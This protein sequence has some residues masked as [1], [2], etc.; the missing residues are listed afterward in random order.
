MGCSVIRPIGSGLR[1]R[2]HATQ[3]NVSNVIARTATPIQNGSGRSPLGTPLH[4]LN[5]IKTIKAATPS[6]MGRMDSSGV[7]KICRSLSCTLISL[8]FYHSIGEHPLVHLP[9]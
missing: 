2:Y 4:E 9:E 3:A 7:L 8:S 1:R 5:T 6:R